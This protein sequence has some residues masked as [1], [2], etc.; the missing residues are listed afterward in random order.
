VDELR[1]IESVYTGP[2]DVIPFWDEPYNQPQQ[3][4]CSVMDMLTAQRKQCA[5]AAA[6]YRANMEYDRIVARA[7]PK[8][9]KPNVAKA[10]TNMR[11]MRKKRHAHNK[12]AHFG[13]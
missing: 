13:W 11:E 9:R 4:I 12:V 8:T 6:V 1:P 2:D 5:Y 7:K 10:H 3:K